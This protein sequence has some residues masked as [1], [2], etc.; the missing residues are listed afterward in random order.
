MRF[1]TPFRIIFLL[2]LMFT[3]L[4]IHC[5]TITTDQKMSKKTYEY[6]SQI[7]LNIKE[8]IDFSDGL[9]MTLMYFSH[10]HSYVDGPTKATA[11]LK[12]TKN[13]LSEEILLSIHGVQDKPDLEYDVLQWNGYEFQLVTFDYDESI[14][15]IVTK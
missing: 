7:K 3:T 9:T 14:V 1:F 2:V 6:N 4:S 15:I 11:Y 10:K 13:Q 8:E 12:I 5:Q